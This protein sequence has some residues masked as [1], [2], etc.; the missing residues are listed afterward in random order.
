MTEEQLCRAVKRL[1]TTTSS[2]SAASTTHGL[3]CCQPVRPS[4][5]E[6][7]DNLQLYHYHCIIS[8]QAYSMFDQTLFFV[9]DGAGWTEHLQPPQHAQG[10]ESNSQPDGT[11]YST[12][13]G[14]H[15]RPSNPTYAAEC[16][17]QWRNCQQTACKG[18][19]AAAAQ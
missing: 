4:R 6:A 14:D 3:G 16:V 18:Q 12:Q 7:F 9:Q 10:H 19:E 13:S 17:L 15:R 11:A 2:D 5:I 1:N 8:D